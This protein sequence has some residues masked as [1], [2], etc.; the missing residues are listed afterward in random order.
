MSAKKIL[1]L[2]AH[3]HSDDIFVPECKDG[4][5]WGVHHLRMD[6]WARKRSWS[7]GAAICYEIKVARSDFIQDDKWPGYLPLCNLLYFVAPPGII[8]KNEVPEGCGLIVTSKNLTRLYTKV[9]A[10][11]REVEIPHAL[12]EYILICRALIDNNEIGY[13]LTREERIKCWRARLAEK[14]DTALLGHAVSGKI[15][16]VVREQIEKVQHENRALREENE[17]FEKVR[18]ILRAMGFES[19]EQVAG[20]WNREEVIRQALTAIPADLP[21]QILACGRRLLMLVE[22][23]KR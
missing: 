9:K 5:T 17:D 7:N 22:D 12:Y 8:E 19:P 6:A 3:R 16:R 20:K 11:Y 15:N 21:A 2:L 10:P 13:G 4:P 1:S 14:D 23:E 18:E